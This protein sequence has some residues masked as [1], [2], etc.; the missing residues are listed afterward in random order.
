MKSGEGEDFL[1]GGEGVIATDGIFFH[2]AEMVVGGEEDAEGAFVG[3]VV[4]AAASCCRRSIIVLL[5]VMSF[6]L[7]GIIIIIIVV[8]GRG[9]G[10]VLFWSSEPAKLPPLNMA[11]CMLKCMKEQPLIQ[12]CFD[13]LGK[14]I[15]E[16]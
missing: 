7:L 15:G 9:G 6:L 12:R 10:G 13:T 1:E 4:V 2:V 16:V 5:L 14:Y 8:V 3:M 11:N